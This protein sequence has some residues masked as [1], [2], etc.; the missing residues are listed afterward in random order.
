[1][2]IGDKSKDAQRFG[3]W[4]QQFGDR[5]LSAK[6]RALQAE[7]E[8]AER[9]YIGGVFMKYSTDVSGAQTY[10][11]IL[12]AAT[13]ARSELYRLGTPKALQAGNVLD[14]EMR[15]RM[16]AMSAK[17]QAKEKPTYAYR[18]KGKP[19]RVGADM[20]QEMEEF[21]RGSGQPTGG[22]KYEK[23]NTHKP[24]DGGSGR[25]D[26]NDPGLV[27]DRKKRALEEMLHARLKNMKVDITK[28]DASGKPIQKLNERGLPMY[29]ADGKPVYEVERTEPADL[30]RVLI[31][32]HKPY[33]KDV[34][35]WLKIIG[36]SE[37]LATANNIAF[38]PAA[39]LAWDAL[40]PGKPYP[41]WIE[42]K[43]KGPKP[44]VAGKKDYEKSPK[45]KVT[46]PPKTKANDN[47]PLGIR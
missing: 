21:E 41:S 4:A 6:A 35:E 7:R 2:P 47:D 17:Q 1:M 34:E 32:E 33:D 3:Q 12:H 9:D 40:Y 19:Y 25:S 8:K 42:K 22:I 18:P 36:E 30:R 46:A 31:G 28:K 43:L 13:R 29:D 14:E 24:S 16:N 11:D 38:T 27:L 26:A 20:V 44:F 5:L 10:D 45:G 39:V 23:F 37:A 15:L